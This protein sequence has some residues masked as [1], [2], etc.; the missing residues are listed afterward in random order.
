MLFCA[1]CAKV[2]NRTDRTAKLQLQLEADKVKVVSV[3]L[4]QS[5]KKVVDLCKPAKVY[6]DDDPWLSY[7]AAGGGGYVLFFSH[8]DTA[9]RLDPR[10]GSLYAVAHYP[11]G[12]RDG[13]AFL[14][15]EAMRGKICGEHITLKV[16]LGPD[17]RKVATVA[18]G[19][20]TQDV[21]HLFRPA[22]D[23][24][25]GD[26]SILYDSAD[27]GRY[28]LTFSPEGDSHTHDSQHDKLSEVMYRPGGQ[29]ETFFLLPHRKRGQPL[30]AAYVT[31]LE[32]GES[33]TSPNKVDALD[34]RTSRQ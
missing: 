23:H 24:A 20:S 9:N 29:K 10:R 21:M 26:H 2:T 16:A 34:A 4:G 19:M 28:L 12:S 13:G 7:Q 32:D 1:A 31:L 11:T 33:H 30:P 17:E 27:G 25:D 3:A 18:L 6:A 22:H 15:P 8:Q 5:A 14:L